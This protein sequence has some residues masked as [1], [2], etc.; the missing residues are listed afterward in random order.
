MNEAERNNK[1]DQEEKTTV[2]TIDII[3]KFLTVLL[4][5][6]SL[7]FFGCGEDSPKEVVKSFI[8]ACEQHN[9]AQASKMV[10]NQRS[11]E[12]ETKDYDLLPYIA[13]DETHGVISGCY[14]HWDVHYYIGTTTGTE[15]YWIS[16]KEP[17]INKDNPNKCTVFVFAERK[18]KTY[19]CNNIGAKDYGK[20][21]PIPPQCAYSKNEVEWEL[22][23]INGKWMITNIKRAKASHVIYK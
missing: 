1:L 3:K 20:T 13:G 23:K 11:G 9:Y 14:A 2:I 18:E 19:T 10:Y 4:C 15:K 16:P 6:L 17:I 12:C 22:E 5:F 7:A 21:E 8:S